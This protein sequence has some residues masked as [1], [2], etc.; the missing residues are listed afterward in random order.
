MS[1]ET[2][3]LFDL[4]MDL[5][6]GMPLHAG[7]VGTRVIAS[8]TGGSFTGPRLSGAVLPSGGD[9]LIVGADGTLIVDVR[10]ALQADDGTLIYMTYGGRIAIPAEH[11]AAIAN[12]ETVE[13]VDPSSYYFR[14]TPLFEAP[15][16]SPHAWLNAVVGV[17]IGRLRKGGVGYRILALK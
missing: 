1:I 12:P 7:P 15:V 5:A 3:F 6:P 17:G 13:G 14:S 10:A 4:T 2:E 8:F 9:W 16:G 11:Q